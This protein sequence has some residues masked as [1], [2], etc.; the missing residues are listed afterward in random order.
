MASFLIVV[1][2]SGALLLLRLR[3]GRPFGW[4]Q[5]IHLAI[6]V[7]VVFYGGAFWMGFRFA[8]RRPGVPVST[9]G[10][11]GPG[12]PAPPLSYEDVETGQRSSLASARGSVV[13][14]YYWASGD[15][16]LPA[17]NQLQREFAKRGLQVLA[18]S[19]EK[20]DV[21]QSYTIGEP[22][23]YRQGRVTRAEL[24]RS[25]PWLGQGVRPRGAVIDRAGSIRE[26]ITAPR[27]VEEWRAAIE[28][29]L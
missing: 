22:I 16:S 8:S 20:R 29:L 6:I 24:S 23:A 25:W 27:S 7:A 13:L 14:A 2:L 11:L 18:L 5:W 21:L 15:A 1:A 19:D 17:L 12:D 10:S 9:V 4:L 28:P 3:Q 26:F